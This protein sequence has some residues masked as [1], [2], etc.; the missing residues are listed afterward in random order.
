MG[1]SGYAKIGKR[2]VCTF[3]TLS[4]SNSIILW[5]LDVI[6]TPKLDVC[7]GNAYVKFEL[8]RVYMVLTALLLGRNVWVRQNACK[9]P[10]YQSVQFLHFCKRSCLKPW[11]LAHFLYT[12]LKNMFLYAC[13]QCFNLLGFKG[14]FLQIF[15]NIFM[16]AK[17]HKIVILANSGEI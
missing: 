16:S 2:H 12:T 1:V 10:F 11:E 4:F 9:A 14:K 6:F 17:P 15:K 3:L 13:V 8:N 5:E 7:K